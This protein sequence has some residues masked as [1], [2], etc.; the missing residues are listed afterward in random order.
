MDLK[1]LM[2]EGPHDGAF[3]SKVMQVNGYKTNKKPIGLYSPQFVAKY[4]SRQY[5]NTS[6]NLTERILKFNQCASEVGCFQTNS[7][8]Y[9]QRNQLLGERS[10]LN[11]MYDRLMGLIEKYNALVEKYN[12]NILRNQELF[13]MMNSN[14]EKESLDF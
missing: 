11:I 6:E 4:L 13:N 2:V 1:I 8:F 12:N 3:I 5:K 9:N 7:D 10:E 14:I